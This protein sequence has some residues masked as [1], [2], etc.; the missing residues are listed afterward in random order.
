M[1]YRN[2]VVGGQ[3][4]KK[5]HPDKETAETEAR[6]LARKTGRPVLTMLVVSETRPEH[7]HYVDTI[8]TD[9]RNGVLMWVGDPTRPALA[10]LGDTLNL[11]LGA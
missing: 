5:D 1:N 6:R 9:H 7:T 8:T 11:V 3:D 2:F 4:P 10:S